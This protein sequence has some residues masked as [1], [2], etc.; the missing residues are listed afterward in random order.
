MPAEL[1]Y[2][3]IGMKDDVPLSMSDRLGVISLSMRAPES[4]VKCPGCKSGDVIRRGTVDRKVHAP[5]I[6]LR[7]TLISIQTPRVQA[8]HAAAFERSSCQRW[9]H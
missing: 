3:A 4:A 1:L 6:G 5:P 8:T 7:T 2:T 9:F